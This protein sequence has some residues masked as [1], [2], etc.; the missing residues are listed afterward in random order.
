MCLV[1]VCPEGVRPVEV[2]PVGV[3]LVGAF[4]VDCFLQG[5]VPFDGVYSSVCVCV[6]EA[7]VRGGA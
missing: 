4:P 5:R 7:K 2:C 1:G 3:R 6:T